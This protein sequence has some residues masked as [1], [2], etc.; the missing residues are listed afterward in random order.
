MVTTNAE[1]RQDLPFLG[2]SQKNS[3]GRPKMA[4]VPPVLGLKGF[5]NYPQPFQLHPSRCLAV[6]KGRSSACILGTSSAQLVLYSYVGDQWVKRQDSWAMVDMIGLAGLYCL[7]GF[8][9]WILHME[10]QLRKEGAAKHQTCCIHTAGRMARLSFPGCD[11]A[12][13]T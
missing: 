9:H 12:G 5:H 1:N 4:S 3:R 8:C 7:S 6:C 2:C 13:A 10:T 11:C